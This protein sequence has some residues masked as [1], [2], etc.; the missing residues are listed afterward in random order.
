MRPRTPAEFQFIVSTLAGNPD[1]GVLV[2][3]LR[4]G[5]IAVFN[6][7]AIS[8]ISDVE[9]VTAA[10]LGASHN[11]KIGIRIDRKSVVK[12]LSPKL[13]D[14]LDV[15]VFTADALGD[16]PDF[17]AT[18]RSEQRS[19]LLECASLDDARCGASH[20]VDGLIAKGHEAGGGIGEETTFVLV[21]RLAEV[22]LPV[23]AH[24][25]VGMHTVAACFVA[26]CA[27]AVLDT[28]V[29]LARE[30]SLPGSVRNAIERIAGDETLC[31]GATIGDRYRV[32]KRPGLQAIDELQQLE[33]ELEASGNVG[34]AGR[35][36]WRD[37]IRSRINWRSSGAPLWPLGQDAAF[38]SDLAE[39]Y[40]SVSGI[41]SGL[42]EAIASNVE[43][44]RT[45]RPLDRESPL[46]QSHGTEFPILQGPMTR[47]SDVAGFAGAVAEG[48]ALPFLALALLRAPQ[49][50]KLL[51]E[52]KELL[53]PRPWGVGILGFVPLELR[54]EQ[55]AVVREFKPPFALIAGGR[56]DQAAKL[57]QY[58]I[59][60]YLHVPAPALLKIYL[61]DGARRFI[62]EGRE[63]GGHVGP[64]TSFVLWDLTVSTLVEAVRDGVKADELHV[65][66]AGGIH[67]A[68]SAA[69]VAAMAAPLAQLGVRIGVLLGTAYLFTEEAV[70]TGAIVETFQSEALK[71][72]Q[73]VLLESGPGHATRCVDT[74]FYDTFRQ[75][76]R[77]LMAEGKTPDEIR[78]ELEGLNLG[79]LRIAS[80]GIVRGADAG[81]ADKVSHIS[82]SADDQRRDGMYM[83]GQ[84]A[85]LRKTTCRVVDL[86]R[87][88]SI[89][90]TAT[91]GGFAPRV[92]VDRTAAAALASRV[93]IVGMGCILPQAGDIRTLWRNILSKR[94]AITEVPRERF[95]IDR[96]YSTDRHARDRVYSKWGGF[97]EEVPFDPLKHGIPPTAM[98]SIDPFQLLTLEVVNQA[99]QDA[100][101]LNRPFNRERTSVILGAS[102]GVGDLGFRY[103]IRA[104]LP[105]YFDSVSEGTLSRLP[106]W[107]EDS[108]A[109]VLLNVA[110]GRVANRLDLGGL[111]FTV[112]A[113]CASSLAALFLAS[114]ELE[115]GASDMVIVGGIDTVN[116]PFGY[117]C[118][119]SAQ[120]LSPRGRC[121]TFDQSA[122]GIAI[123][124]G[125]VTLV[126][127]R[128]EDA[129]RDGDRI[130]AVVRSVAGSSDGRGKGLTAPR[131]EGQMRVLQ[132]AYAVAN[133]SPASVGLVEAHGTGTVAGDTAEVAALSRVFTAAGAPP[134]TCAVGSIKSMIGHTKSAAGVSGVAKVAL[135]L[136][137]KILPPTLHVTTPNAKLREP[138]SPLYVNSEARPWISP[139]GQP[140]R[141]GVSSFGFGGTNFH[142]LIEEY[143]GQAPGVLPSVAPVDL[144]PAELAVW[145]APSAEHLAATLDELDA[146]LAAGADVPLRNVAAGLCRHHGAKLQGTLRLA[147][148]AVDVD[149]L[150]KKMAVAR[151]AL[152]SG[153]TALADSTGIYLGR[154]DPEV[155]V[156]FLFPGQGSQY[157]DM[158]R[159]L[160]LHFADIRHSLEIANRVTA[161]KYARRL[162]DYVF[163]P[164]SF[165]KEEKEARSRE[166]TD[167]TIAQPALG[168]V[169]LGV[170]RLLER[171]GVRPSF[172]AGHSYGEYVA[173]CAAGAFS[174][175]TLFEVSAARG[176]FIKQAT[177]DA[178]GTMAAVGASADAVRKLV[179]GHADVW[180]ANLN[181]P[182]QTVIAGSH[183]AIEQAIARF[184]AAGVTARKI[185]VACAFHSPL[186]Q[187]AQR[188]LAALLA[189]IPIGPTRLP[190]FSN[191]L[192]RSYSGEPEEIRQVLS[193][194]L[195][196]PVR[197]VDEI[198]DMYS[199][200]A[201]V[202]VEVGPRSVL[203]GLSRESLSGRNALLLSVDAPEKNGLVQLLHVLG[204]LA[205][206]GVSI[207]FDALWEGRSVT[208]VRPDHL[209]S[210]Q[211]KALPPHVWM[212]SGGRSRRMAEPVMKN[213]PV[214]EAPPKE[215]V[216]DSS[217][218]PALPT[219]VE[220]DISGKGRPVMSS[221]EPAAPRNSGITQPEV[222]VVERL[223]G[224]HE[225]VLRQFQ[226]VMS[227]FLQTQAL[228]MTSYL[229]GAGRSAGVP[230]LSTLRQPSVPTLPAAPSISAPEPLATVAAPRYDVRSV[231]PEPVRSVAANPV[232]IVRPE[233]QAVPPPAPAPVAAR[234]A[235]A[236]ARVEAG[237]VLKQLVH[238]VSDRTGYPEEMLDIDSNIEADLGID[239]I[240]RMEILAAFQQAHASS[241]NGTFQGAMETLTTIKTLRETATA[242]TALL[243]PKAEAAIA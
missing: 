173:L 76:R 13:I 154:F 111:N 20:H 199:A 106:E 53:G 73:T 156:A 90:S 5:Q 32:Y 116:S 224:N 132:R 2:A 26:G 170:S 49:V 82:I 161:G 75:T 89:G 35:A 180:I 107:T 118:F 166:L 42:R 140:R 59:A 131:P 98:P 87:D 138:G 67:D 188:D 165:T 119:S 222:A 149:D 214:K 27:G 233:I 50:R 44:A 54:E 217:P 196:Q 94:D 84:V 125:L 234:P 220:S 21:Q 46:A 211:S 70:G 128:V 37:A 43:L 127:K 58:G 187:P 177:R 135:S 19:V 239:S 123:S 57:E 153:K 179:D 210:M 105:M 83:I 77:R 114:R 56:P 191:S 33:S 198:V 36:G 178:S 124:E 189:R 30:S 95:D 181:A 148:V 134:Q 209:S 139:D 117:L 7:E 223:P 71:C 225:D 232:P 122:D 52:T 31:L 4:A 146:A 80:K 159:D 167:T 172:A 193:A 79:R 97:L 171:L 183:E 163:P 186:V 201:R 226:H 200:G 39:R 184:A 195:V 229:Q 12:L 48:G 190:V 60:T 169:E 130:Y 102:G 243:A 204:Q 162:S 231:E 29:L 18:L 192:G 203:T 40:R 23:Y 218:K 205:V 168:A 63:C 151:R 176:Q 93:A 15:V 41:L 221:Q 47:V 3:A 207:N 1:A 45:L 182:A 16:L 241:A 202:F 92:S 66:F 228:V 206:A 99:L 85:A 109:G 240:K 150:R 64:R 216:S 230:Q 197:F 145:T 115:S 101:Y 213:I 113:A 133:V 155:K 14:A 22:G 142:V 78:M 147:V 65:V 185:P 152:L 69:M 136:F 62:F 24:G 194:H 141:A 126:L 212:V 110:A 208:A 158:H 9:V 112:D 129:E 215:A 96:Y 144:W 55:L 175:E 25:G 121:S 88:V 61:K 51:Q 242:L 10:L 68:A 108:F 91:L 137:H 157:P 160:S 72:N 38:A 237:D 100:G 81:D 74:P 143:D 219:P 86:H 6:L 8:D 238:I 28:Q 11:G 227:Q 120:A 17:V 174:T 164:P 104:G 235:P 34:E 236:A 103:G